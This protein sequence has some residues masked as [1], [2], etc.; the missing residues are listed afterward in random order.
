MFQRTIITN[1]SATTSGIQ[2]AI[3]EQKADDYKQALLKLIPAEVVAVYLTAKNLIE[4]AVLPKLGDAS[5]VL[6][7]QLHWAVFALL[8]VLTPI[9]LWRMTEVRQLKQLALSTCSFIVWVFALGGPFDCVIVDVQ[10][11]GLLATLLMVL[12][13]FIAPLFFQNTPTP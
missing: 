9:Y 12:F 13:V 3:T 11:R 4:Q 10:L 8:V 5:V 6:K 2:G 1:V 7:C